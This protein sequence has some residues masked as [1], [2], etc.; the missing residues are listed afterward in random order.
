MKDCD[1]CTTKMVCV[2]CGKQLCQPKDNH[3]CCIKGHYAYPVGGVVCMDCERKVK[4][5]VEGQV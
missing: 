1:L 4:K 5:E 2:S 3:G